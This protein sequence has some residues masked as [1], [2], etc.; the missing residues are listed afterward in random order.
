MKNI[1]SHSAI[2]LTRQI[3]DKE[4][5]CENVV[6]QFLEHIEKYNGFINDISDLHE[7]LT[8]P[9]LGPVTRPFYG[10]LKIVI[11]NSYKMD[12]IINFIFLY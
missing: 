6:R 12:M 8:T 7:L 9:F 2:E 1:I 5:S 3:L 11:N 4:I 10:T